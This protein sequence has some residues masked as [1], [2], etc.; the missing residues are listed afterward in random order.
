[1]VGPEDVNADGS[2]EWKFRWWRGSRVAG[3]LEI[4]GS[5]VDGDGEPITATIPDGYGLTGFQASSVTF[6]SSGCWN[7]IGSVLHTNGDAAA[8]LSFV[9]LVMES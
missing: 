8:T 1:M 9:V 7:I 4:E 5:R 6:P 2:I 3:Q